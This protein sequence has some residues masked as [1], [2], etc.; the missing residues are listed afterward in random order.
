MWPATNFRRVRRDRT[1]ARLDRTRPCHSPFSTRSGD[2]LIW[3]FWCV[4]FD[5]R[6]RQDR[7]AHQIDRQ[8]SPLISHLSFHG[9]ALHWSLLGSQRSTSATELG[10]CAATSKNASAEPS[11]MRRPCSQSRKAATLTPIMSGKSVYD[12]SNFSHTLFTS[13]GRNVVT[14]QASLCRD[15]SFPPANASSSPHA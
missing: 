8:E 7:P 15:V 4:W 6:E 1:A 12:A 3:S 14:W 11:G 10:L 13:A 2:W 5:K 9:S